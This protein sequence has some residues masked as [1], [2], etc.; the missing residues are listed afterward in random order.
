ML[1]RT[2]VKTAATHHLA[3]LF[4]VMLLREKTQVSP[5]PK[6]PSSWWGRLV[7]GRQEKR[8]GEHMSGA[9]KQHQLWISAVL[10]AFT[11]AQ[12]VLNFHFPVVLV[13]ILLTLASV[14]NLWP[15]LQEIYGKD[16]SGGEWS[17]AFDSPRFRLHHASLDKLLGLQNQKECED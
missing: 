11:S 3:L 17:G 14:D 13:H 2:T 10:S 6:S 9:E 1:L 16:E 4:S 7:H 8:E 5:T 15:V 12:T